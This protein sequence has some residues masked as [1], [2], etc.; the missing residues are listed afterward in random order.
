[1][2]EAREIAELVSLLPGRTELWLVRALLGDISASADEVVE[3]G[4]LRY[5]DA[6]LSFRHELGRLAVE[7]TLLRGR[8]RELHKAIL[9]RL[10]ER[11]ADLSQVVHHAVNAEDADVLVEYAPR[12]AHQAAL[13][14]AHREAAAHLATAIQ[15]ADRLS[16]AARAHL[17]E[18]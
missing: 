15:H 6:A 2:A 9:Q 10:I 14:G 16:N 13:A 4:L 7:S 12:A 17:F 5:N 11:K 1:S 18:S 3:R 8:A